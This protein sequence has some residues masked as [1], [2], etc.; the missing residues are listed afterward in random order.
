MADIPV[1]ERI[2]VPDAAVETKAVRA[3][4][5]GGQNVNKLATKIQM[6]VDLDR[7]PGL[8]GED[9]FRVRTFLKS[10][11]DAEGRLLV[12]SQE[13]RDQSRNRDDCA[14]K[15]AELIRAALFR[16]KVRRRTRPT[17]ASKERRIEAKRH[18]A[19]RLKN[20]KVDD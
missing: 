4:G 2:V 19:D 17:H 11:L 6:R 9:L 12:M 10:R 3:S 5:P 13:T 18:Q 7:I 15:V 14:R 8:Q 16:P 1:N 20:R